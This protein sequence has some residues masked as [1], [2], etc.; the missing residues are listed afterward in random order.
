VRTALPDLVA[1]IDPGVWIEDK[2]LS[3]VV[4]TR[5][6]LKPDIAW[7]TLREPVADLAAA[8]GLIAVDGKQVLEVRIPGLSKADAITELLTDDVR[9]VLY[10]GD[11]IGDIPAF[12]AVSDWRTGEDHGGNRVGDRAGLTVGVGD[13]P[14]LAAHVDVLLEHPSELAELL[15]Q[16]V[17]LGLLGELS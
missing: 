13:E 14:A 8:H 2:G 12:D 17:E 9:A 1:S 5:R 7:T 16:L 11:D 3:V 10:A 15:R 4:H 6:A